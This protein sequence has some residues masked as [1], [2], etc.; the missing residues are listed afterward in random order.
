M[1][2]SGGYTPISQRPNVGSTSG[3]QVVTTTTTQNIEE[4]KQIDDNFTGV[5]QQVGQHRKSG[6]DG[7][8]QFQSQNNDGN[9]N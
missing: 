6:Q 3:P 7:P 8:G 1:P 4:T 9:L 5:T 2:I